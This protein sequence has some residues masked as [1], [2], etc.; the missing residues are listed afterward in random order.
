M[1][2]FLLRLPGHL[3]QLQFF[4]INQNNIVLVKKKIVDE[5]QPGF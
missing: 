5:L 2:W 4:Y 3:S 1:S